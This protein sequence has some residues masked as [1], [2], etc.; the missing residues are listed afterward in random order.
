MAKHVESHHI[1]ESPIWTGFNKIRESAEIHIIAVEIIIT[2][3][4]AIISIG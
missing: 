2:A 3:L 4:I 1:Q